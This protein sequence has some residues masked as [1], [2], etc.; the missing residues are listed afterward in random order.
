M[1]PNMVRTLFRGIALLSLTLL[2]GQA[3]AQDTDTYDADPPER[4][5]RLSYISGDVVLQPAGEEEWAP[6]LLNRPLTTGD[7]VWTEPGARAEISVG[8]ADVRLDSNTGFSFLNVDN[9]VVQMRITAGVMNVSVLSLAGN[10]QIEIDTPNAAVSLL[11]SG[12]YRIEVNDDGDATVIRIAQGSAEVTG[13]S[14][15]VIVHADQVV[16]FTGTDELVAH[17]D[18]LGPPDEFDSWVL[19]RDRRDE[20]AA[21]SRTAQYVSPDVTGYEDLDDNGSWSSEP[22]YG[23]VWTPTRVALGWSPYRY[24]RW[25]WVTPWGWT[26]IDDA[27]WGYAPFHYGRW[28]H[29]RNRWCWVPGP[30]HMRAVYAPALVGWVGS[31][32][33]SISW[34]P[35]GPREVYIPGRRYSRHYFERV[36]VSN[37][38][39]VNRALHRALEERGSNYHYR[40]R[41]AP[42]GVTTV[43]RTAFTTAGRVHEHRDRANEGRLAN[44]PATAVA[45]QIAPGRESRLGGRARANVRV[46]PRAIVDRQVVVRREPPPAAARFARPATQIPDRARD[47]GDRGDRGNNRAAFDRRADVRDRPE[48]ED[49]PWR[50]GRPVESTPQVASPVSDPRGI[51]ARVREDGERQVLAEQQRREAEQRQREAVRQRWQRS[52]DQP[53][54][55]REQAEAWRERQGRE[56]VQRQPDDPRQAPRAVYQREQPEPREQ[57]RHRERPVQREQPEQRERHVE[58]P[59]AQRPQMERPPQVERP[60]REQPERSESRGQSE[61]RPQ[62]GRRQDNGSPRPKD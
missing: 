21:S 25:V 4:A 54:E 32:G 17:F 18:R 58:R 47:R 40:N 44:A 22:E 50:S 38:V 29:V 24:G 55:Q 1:M 52:D 20:R 14:Q 49:R 61:S 7:K 10:E 12:S 56:R 36:N 57:P 23:Y 8:P 13:P 15:N 35:L 30:R 39:I 2:G 34:F 46:P 19:D 48:R 42:G 41:V 11:R 62:P 5:A 31:P 28:A 60:R 53:R 45:P 16:T 27:P 33:L 59:P 3:Y 9:N 51:A 37:T 6:A 26:W 43:S